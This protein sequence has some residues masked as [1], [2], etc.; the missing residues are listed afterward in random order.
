MAGRIGLLTERGISMK[1]V[2][3]VFLALLGGAVLMALGGCAVSLGEDKVGRGAFASTATQ[4]ALEQEKGSSE[5]S[6]IPIEDNISAGF[7]VGQ[8]LEGSEGRIHYSYYLPREYDGSREYPMMVVMPGYD[9]MWFGQESQGSNLDWNGFRVW[10]QMEED[11]IV[12]SA[13]LTDWGERSARQAIELTEYFLECFSVDPDRVYAAGY[14]AG[15]ETMSRAVA[16]RP[17]IYASYLHGSSQWDGEYAPIAENAVAVY[18]FMAQSDEY[19]GS[20]RA[21]DAYDGLYEAYRNEGWTDGQINR[22]LQL[23]IPDDAYFNERGIYGNYHG[24]GNV[25]FENASILEWVVSH[26]KSYPD[27]MILDPNGI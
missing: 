2:C 18:I 13:Q 15:G 4:F 9:R 19:Y 1:K 17:D 23:E 14:S 22:V 11:M 10:T 12:V 20:Q 25:L 8:I 24:G 3:P 16:M 26:S 27:T 6:Q 7:T 5:L 21:Q